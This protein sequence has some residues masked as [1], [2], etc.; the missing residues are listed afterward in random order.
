MKLSNIFILIVMSTYLGMHGIQN[1]SYVQEKKLTIEDI[2]KNYTDRTIIDIIPFKE[3]FVLVE[4]KNS[5]RGAS[6]FDL[7]N[8]KT[9][10]MN[11]VYGSQYYVKIYKIVDEDR[12]IF[13]ANGKN[14]INK[15]WKFPFL[16]DCRRVEDNERFIHFRE[17]KYFPIEDSVQF[18][19]DKDQVIIDF[20][21]RYHEIEIVFGP[22]SEETLAYIAGG[23]PSIPPVKTSFDKKTN[24]LILTFEG[25][26]VA[27][28]L[29][30]YFVI[31]EEFFY[32]FTSLALKE[33]GNNTK[34]VL[35]LKNSAKFYTGNIQRMM[36]L[37]H[38]ELP[39][40]VITFA[41][42]NPFYY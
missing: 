32:D 17:K 5:P 10:E 16:E 29:K 19:C 12:I 27:D 22:Q 25:T 2:K 34:V 41:E 1:E 13:L 3:D 39:Y 38:G 37:K 31:Y 26:K 42:Q 40:V 23:G 24:A 28:D 11:R 4:W 20:T 35:G 14:H 6:R 30:D 8:S 9:G 21:V 7:Y 36:K 18:G 15:Y 33:E